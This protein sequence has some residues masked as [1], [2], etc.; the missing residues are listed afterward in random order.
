ME[1]VALAG[2]PLADETVMYAV[3]AVNPAAAIFGSCGGALAL[4]LAVIAAGE[5]P[6]GSVSEAATPLADPSATVA[7]AATVV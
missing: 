3:G 2:S 5:A 7:P 6:A 1:I 4:T